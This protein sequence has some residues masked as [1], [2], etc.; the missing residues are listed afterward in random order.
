MANNNSK[1]RRLIAHKEHGR[2]RPGTAVTMFEIPKKIAG[3]RGSGY[4]TRT[5]AIAV[6]SNPTARRTRKPKV[7]FSAESYCR[8]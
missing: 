7:A 3:N 4:S 1:A 2:K 5:M 6:A 8:D